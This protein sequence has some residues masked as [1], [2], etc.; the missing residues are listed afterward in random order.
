[1]PCARVTE[2][3]VGPLT[4]DGIAHAGPVAIREPARL[5][6]YAAWHCLACGFA[7]GPS[8]PAHRLPQRF[9]PKPLLEWGMRSVHAFEDKGDR[10]QSAGVE[11]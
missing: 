8:V 3:H 7:L 1:M 6:H 9:R 10:G 4:W 5:P 11:G 2:R